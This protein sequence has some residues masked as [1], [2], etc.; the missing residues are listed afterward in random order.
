[1][2]SSDTCCSIGKS[3]QIV[4]YVWPEPIPQYKKISLAGDIEFRV[5]KKKTL[6]KITI[7]EW[8]F[9]NMRIMQE[10]LKQNIVFHALLRHD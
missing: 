4:N 6:D 8:G 1:M 2:A 5:G 10:L 9:G 7:E 3:L